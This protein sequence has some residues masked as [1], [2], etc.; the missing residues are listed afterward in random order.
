MRPARLYTSGSSS[1]PGSITRT[2]PPRGTSGRS[3]AFSADTRAER[4]PTP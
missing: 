3:R 4:V 1:S 2:E